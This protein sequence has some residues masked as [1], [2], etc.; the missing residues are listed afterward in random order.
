MLVCFGQAENLAAQNR[1]PAGV[2]GIQNGVIPPPGHYT[3][4]Y[5][6]FY[7]ADKLATNNGSDVNARF[8]VFAHVIAPRHIWITENKIFGADYGLDLTIPFVR[9]DVTIGTTENRQFGLGDIFFEPVVLGWHLPRWD[10]AFAH[11]IFFPTGDFKVS[12]PASPGRGY[13]TNL[14][15]LGITYRLDADKTWTFSTAHRFEFN[16]E[17]TKLHITPGSF[18]SLEW[19]LSKALPNNIEA[20]LVG[21]VQRQ[22]TDDT[23]RGVTY[24]SNNRSQIFGIGPEL[25]VFFPGIR[26]HVAT[27]VLG[28]FGA[29][30]RAEGVNSWLVFTRIW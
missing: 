12:Q 2:E 14:L 25:D 18:Y 15:A 23:G 7:Y 8:K 9:T 3:K 10:F 27:R 24:N 13:W 29:R 16:A 20:G 4:L 1:Y 11:G 5:N 6:F 30:N 19:G 21:F 22:L 26:L 28:E 17:N